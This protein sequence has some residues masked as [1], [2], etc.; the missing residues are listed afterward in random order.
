MVEWT[1]G[2]MTRDHTS[3]DL[4]GRNR[5]GAL[6]ANEGIFWKGLSK[7]VLQW[8]DFFWWQWGG[9]GGVEWQFTVRK[10]REEAVALFQDE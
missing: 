7:G 2:R 8:A 1:M 6:Q 3:E 4:W 9:W 5:A 10:S